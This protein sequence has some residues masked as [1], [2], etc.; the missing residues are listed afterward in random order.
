[1]LMR[2]AIRLVLLL[3]LLPLA[4]CGGGGGSTAP[5]A[6]VSVVDG[7]TGSAA[8]GASVA[9]RPGDSVTIE[10]AGYLRRDTVVPR[11]GVVSLWP[12]TVDE[13]FVRTLVYSESA[14]RNRLVRWPG[15]TITVPRDFPSDV[16][17]AVRPWVTLVPSDTPAVTILIDPSNPAFAPQP[18]EVIGVT[19]SQVADADAHI[20]SSQIIFKTEADRRLPG[21]LAHEF[22][23]ALGLNHSARPQDLMFPNTARTT[24]TFSVDERVLL[25]MMYAHRR[26]GQ[27]APDNDQALGQAGTGIVRIIA[28]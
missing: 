26:P 5:S 10:R 15:T 3:P 8:A 11:D 12:I 1:M 4:G 18:P 25:T 21:S 27:I 23:H 24:L 2:R 19:L 14:L 6:S 22:G 28:N 16:A 7:V 17:D 20:L 13:A 9:G